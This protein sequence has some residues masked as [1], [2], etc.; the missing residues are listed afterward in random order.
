MGSRIQPVDLI[1]CTYEQA[2]QQLI[3]MSKH[4]K[5]QTMRTCDGSYWLTYPVVC[6]SDGKSPFTLNEHSPGLIQ[7]T[8]ILSNLKWQ[9]ICNTKEDWEQLGLVLNVETIN[10]KLNPDHHQFF[11]IQGVEIDHEMPRIECLVNYLRRFPSELMALINQTIWAILRRYFVLDLYIVDEDHLGSGI[12]MLWRL[13]I[14]IQKILE[15]KS[16]EIVQQMISVLNRYISNYEEYCEW[17]MAMAF[18]IALHE[19]ASRISYG[20]IDQHISDEWVRR[21]MKLIRDTRPEYPRGLVDTFLAAEQSLLLGSGYH[22]N[23]CKTK[24]NLFSR[25]GHSINLL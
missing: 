9:D 1:S 11:S 20:A 25:K 7:M 13:K 14:M 15:H 17:K 3:A 12:Y 19:R 8:K 10:P 5:N 22:S 2:F 16:E 23:P 18:Y 6:L 21:Q 24:W 4:L